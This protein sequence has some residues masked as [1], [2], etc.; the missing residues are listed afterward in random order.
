MNIQTIIHQAQLRL[1]PSRQAIL[2]YIKQT[3]KPVSIEEIKLYLQKNHYI[4]DDVTIYRT[5]HSFVQKDIV[6]QIDFHEGKF[7]YE[8]ANL[9]HHHHIVCTGC[10]SIQDIEHCL[11]ETAEQSIEK[12]TGYVISSHSLE[13]F[14]LCRKCKSKK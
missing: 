4:F 1:T 5:I 11:K 2:T 7:R 14:G 3:E 10:G 9:P 13:F 8:I 12:N 6:K